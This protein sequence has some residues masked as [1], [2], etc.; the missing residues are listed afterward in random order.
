M[1]V[2]G[3]PKK[4]DSGGLWE[5]ALRVLGQ[6]AHSANELRQKLSKRSESAADVAAVMGKLRDYGLADDTKFSEAFASSRLQ[7]QGFGRF[8]VLRDLRSKRVSG[9]IAEAAVEKTFA[10]RDEAELIQRF[11]ERKYRGKKLDEFLK[12]EKNLASVYRR[13]RTAGFSSGKSFSILKRYAHQI[14]D[15][16][17]LEED[18]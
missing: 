7:N 10:G 4:L 11:L 2:R 18:G 13:L 9:N 6:R 16:S 1:A 3:K 12:E 8:R 14:E 17:A 15:W 5:Y